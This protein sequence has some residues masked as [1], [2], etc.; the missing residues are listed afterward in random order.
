MKIKTANLKL[1]ARR[2]P[3]AL[4]GLNDPAPGVEVELSRSKQGNEVLKVRESGQPWRTLHSAVDPVKE[5]ERLVEAAF[6][7][8]GLIVA[9]GFGLGFHLKALLDK[10]GPEARL[11]V[12]EPAAQVIE[13][14]LES[15]D[16]G[17]LLADERLELIVGP[18]PKEAARRLGQIQ[19]KAG[20]TPLNV[21]I[22]R[23]SLMAMPG[24]YE[25]MAAELER[26]ERVKIESRLSYPKFKSDSVR[27]LVVHGKYLL[28]KELIG[29]LK[30]LGHEARLMWLRRREAAAEEVIARLM[31]E[32]IDF[33][34]DF[35]L[36]VNHL[37]FDKGG[38]VTDFLAAIKMPYASWYV[39]SPLNIIRHHRLDRSPWGMIFLWDKDYIAEVAELG[40]ERVEYLP[41]AA[42]ETVFR[43]LKPSAS[44]K[45][46]PFDLAFV[47]N[48]MTELIAENEA[49]LGLPEDVR[50][51]IDRAAGLFAASRERYAAGALKQAGLAEHPYAQ[52][53]GPGEWIDLETLVI[54]RA[55]QLYRLEAVEALAGQGLTVIG[56]GG[57]RELSDLDGV[58]L[59]RPVNYYDELPAVYNVTAVNLNLTSLQMKT[60]L[61]QRVFDVPACGAFLLTDHRDQIEDLFE[62]GKEF[63]SFK[64]LDEARDLASFYLANPGERQ[65]IAAAARRRVLAQ[66][67]YPRRLTILIEAMRRRFA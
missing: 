42:D 46:G 10:A 28:L 7:P 57:W 17:R 19:L 1:L 54:R 34:P 49:R 40:Y 59:H 63:V 58:E 3:R 43:P 35:V 64:S 2:H 18:D 4:A 44:P 62:P 39:D 6:E 23:P 14:A 8:G 29:G 53:L 47:G 37:G 67:T 22:H 61:N 51:I 48:S 5:A 12:I 16:L 15:R 9:L 25:P 24:L 13:A 32:I 11:V 66:H 60:G 45:L 55:T 65:K 50:P 27:V 30:G 52:G 26:I 31:G 36:T 21:F 41:L 33:K 56:D 20:F 38:V